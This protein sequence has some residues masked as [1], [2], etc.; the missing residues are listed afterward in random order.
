MATYRI[1]DITKIPFELKK[2]I[3]ILYGRGFTH[4]Q[5]SKMVG[6]S[7]PFV[8]EVVRYF[9]KNRNGNWVLTER[10]ENLIIKMYLETPYGAKKIGKA[11]KMDHD[12]VYRVLKRNK[13]SRRK[14]S[15]YRIYNLNEDFFECIDSEEK[16]YWLGF[17]M[18]DGCISYTRQLLLRIKNIDKELLVKAQKS[19]ET[20]TPIKPERD[21][22]VNLTLNS[23]KLCIDLAK[24]GI[25]P[26]KT[27][28]AQ[29]PNLREDLVRHFIRGVF[30]GDGSVAMNLNK[31]TFMFSISGTHEICSQIQEEMM[32]ELPLKKTRIIPDRSIYRVSYGGL[33][34]VSKIGEWLY[35]DA[36]IYMERKKRI[37]DNILAEFKLRELQGAYVE[38]YI[39]RSENRFDTVISSQACEET[40]EKGS[41]TRGEAKA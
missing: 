6:K 32:K 5:I 26:N 27:F 14:Y 23:K 1:K 12:V 18:A 28:V 8:Q 29:L 3:M 33:I 20:N 40:H 35:K 11:L 15:D 21:N 25:V 2:R 34:Q 7:Q 36:T 16:A 13:I 39:R 4:L 30:D 17:I 19:F 24:Y 31:R 10:K 9:H 37:F 41:E 22:M 38:R